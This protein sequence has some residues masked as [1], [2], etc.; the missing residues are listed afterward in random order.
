MT[1][2]VCVG[3]PLS[4][5]S[6]KAPKD[7]GHTMAFYKPTRSFAIGGYLDGGPVPVEQEAYVVMSFSTA[8]HGAPPDMTWLLRHHALP[9]AGV[10]P[11]LLRIYQAAMV[12]RDEL[13]GPRTSDEH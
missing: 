11:E 8:R 4:G 9:P 10:L 6:Y 12:D 7:E 2:M 1:S 13:F 5:S 3:G